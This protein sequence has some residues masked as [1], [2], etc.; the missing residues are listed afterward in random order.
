M[1]TLDKKANDAKTV[2]SATEKKATNGEVVKIEKPEKSTN[3][4]LQEAKQKLSTIVGPSTATQRIK[5]FDMM[6]KLIEKYEFLKAKQDDLS[7]FMVSRDGLKERVLIYGEN[8]T[9]FEI[10]NTQIIEEILN[11]CHD[12]LE[13]LV[14]DSEETLLNFNI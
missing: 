13:K 11:I 6:G 3:A 14:N 8:Q 1:N 10:N 2:P 7:S 4:G 12:K 5:N 9:V